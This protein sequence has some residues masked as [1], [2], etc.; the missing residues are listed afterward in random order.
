MERETT[1]PSA[2]EPTDILLPMSQGLHTDPLAVVAFLSKRRDELANELAMIE[3][4]LKAA[5]L[6]VPVDKNILRA[7]YKSDIPAT[8]RECGRPTRW[9]TGTGFAQ[10]QPDCS[11]RAQGHPRRAKL[12]IPQEVWDIL[13]GGTLRV[14]EAEESLDDDE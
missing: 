4:S 5:W 9:R 3:A 10:C 14:G 1:E 6:V 7:A 2:V 12:A 8:C 13:E 11:T